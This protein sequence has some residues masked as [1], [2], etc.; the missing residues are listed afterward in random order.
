[1]KDKVAIVTG[2]GRGIG[3]RIVERFVREGAA[4]VIAEVDTA[5]GEDVCRQVVADGGKALFVQTDVASQASVQ[6]MVEKGVEEF[7]RIDTL[8]NNAA[9]TGHRG[10]FLDVD[11]QTWERI[12]A[13][14]QTGVFLCSQEVARVMAASGGGSIVNISSVNGLIPQPRNWAYGSA[15]GGVLA[16][17]RGLAT[18]LTC[19][20]IR[21][22]AIAPGAIQ[23]ELPPGVEPKPAP[24]A[25]MGRNGRP[26][27]IAAA[28]L[29][30]A[31]DEASY[32]TGQVLVVDGGAMVNGHN[33]YP[34]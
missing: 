34:H 28:A 1:M 4:V 15:K 22:N 26:E 8:V 17:T 31:S 10:D 19:H 3:R 7:G 14:T 13:I 18:E 6:D 11:L 33:I 12:L 32:I 29:F 21:V 9:A 27:E 23:S 5:T 25:L 2:S 30:L 16:L 20:G 24:M